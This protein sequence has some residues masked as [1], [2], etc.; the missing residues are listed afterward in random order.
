MNVEKYGHV[1]EVLRTCTSW[2]ATK[3]AVS[4]LYGACARICREM[5]FDRLIS[6]TLTDESGSSLKGAGWRMVADTKPCA[7]GWRKTDHLTRIHQP[8]M[9]LVKHRWECEL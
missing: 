2:E 6:Y 8:V 4:F 5:G 7:E 1:A 3:G 9:S